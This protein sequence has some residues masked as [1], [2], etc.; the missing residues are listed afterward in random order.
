MTTY[1]IYNY[2]IIY[3]DSVESSIWK[4]RINQQ[5]E[6]YEYDNLVKCSRMDFDNPDAIA[7]QIKATKLLDLEASYGYPHC[8]NIN[9]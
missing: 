7:L 2:L 4:M 8:K 6:Q 3:A 5:L 9:I 1:E